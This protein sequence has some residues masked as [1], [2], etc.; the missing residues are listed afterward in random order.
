M[1]SCCTVSQQQPQPRALAS[2]IYD[3][4]ID[5]NR[6]E[7]LPFRSIYESNARARR[8]H[9]EILQFHA[10][11]RAQIASLLVDY[12]GHFRSRAEAAG[13]Y[14]EYSAVRSRLSALNDLFSSRCVTLSPIYYIAI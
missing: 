13:M 3:A 10:E 4:A 2:L 8:E 12:Q 5:R 1:S 11:C 9:N 14:D 7:V 6:K